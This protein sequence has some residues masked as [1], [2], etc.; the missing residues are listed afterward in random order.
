M[1]IS[2]AISRIARYVAVGHDRFTTETHWQDAVIRQLEIVGEATQRLSPG[3]RDRHHEVP[4]RRIADLRDVLIH[5]DMGVDVEAVQESRSR[6][7]SP[8]HA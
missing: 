4:C 3:L 1:H 2:D 8:P 5:D 6:R 7:A